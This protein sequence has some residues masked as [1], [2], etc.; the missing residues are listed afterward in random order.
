LVIVTQAQKSVQCEL[1]TDNGQAVEGSSGQC[2]EKVMPVHCEVLTYIE[3]T[4]VF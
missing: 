3:Q 2:V 4:L 1:L